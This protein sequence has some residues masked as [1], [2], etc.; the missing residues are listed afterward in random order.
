MSSKEVNFLRAILKKTFLN[1]N[2]KLELKRWK[3]A[4]WSNPWEETNRD[5]KFKNFIISSEIFK[6]KKPVIAIEAKQSFGDS[7][8]VTT[9]LIL[10]SMDHLSKKFRGKSV[11]D[12]GTGSGVL[13]IV[14]KK[15]GAKKIIAT[16]I[17]AKALVEARKNAK[18]NKTSIVFKKT[19]KIPYGKF[20][21]IFCN[22]LF[23]EVFRLIPKMKKVLTPNG[24]MIITGFNESERRRY[25]KCCDEN[26]LKIQ[27]EYKEQQWI[28]ALLRNELFSSKNSTI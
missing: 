12:I 24:I 9:R 26:G 17:D 5:L 13:S 2:L 1:E 28:A 11:L 27:R 10:K 4:D 23:P 7:R 16:E 8:H 20:D 15:L 18:K 14:A 6:S 25:E 19:A 3:A 22:V 21:F